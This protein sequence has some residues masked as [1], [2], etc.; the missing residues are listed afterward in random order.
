MKE[1][2][3]K[4]IT[5]RIIEKREKNGTSIKLEQCESAWVSIPPQAGRKKHRNVCYGCSKTSVDGSTVPTRKPTRRHQRRRRMTGK[6]LKPFLLT[7]ACSSA[8]LHRCRVLCASAGPPGF[9][10]AKQGP[11]LSELD[12]SVVP[13]SASLLA[14]LCLCAQSRARCCLI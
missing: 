11:L 12:H 1:I 7:A 2:K 13:P 9:V 8:G 5:I 10:C 4:K 3:M 14:H 6:T